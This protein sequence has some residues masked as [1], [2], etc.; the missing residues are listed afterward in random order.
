[1][2]KDIFN[3]LKAALWLLRNAIYVFF[4]HRVGKHVNK[5]VTLTSVYK[6]MIII[7]A[8]VGWPPINSA[9]QLDMELMQPIILCNRCVKYG[10]RTMPCIW[11]YI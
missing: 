1:M 11:M 10:I 3:M 5:S 7:R 4:G 8:T 6:I 2:Y 9:L